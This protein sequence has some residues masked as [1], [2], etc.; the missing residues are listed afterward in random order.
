MKNIRQSL[1][2]V[3][4]RAGHLFVLVLLIFSLPKPDARWQVAAWALLAVGL[5]IRLWASGFIRKDDEV[6]QAGPYALCR[7]PL[8]LGSML[9]GLAYCF[10]SGF[11]T[12]FA[13]LAVVF[14]PV[15]WATVSLEQERLSRKFGEAYKAYRRRTMAFVPNVA[16]LLSRSAYG[17]FD[18]TQL[19]RNRELGGAAVQVLV[20]VIFTL[21]W[22]FPGSL[23][24]LGR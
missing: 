23:L 20:G 1:A 24:H 22:M 13:I 18:V 19:R 17:G 5:I 6:T 14:I 4:V 8:Y 16:A 3:R 10:F 15:Y 7:N 21:R 9:T 12:S 11:K 2:R